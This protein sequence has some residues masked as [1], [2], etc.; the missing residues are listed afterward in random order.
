MVRAQP[1][2]E[3]VSIERLRVETRLVPKERR[4]D[5]E[6][7]VL[8]SGQMCRPRFAPQQRTENGSEISAAAIAHLM[9]GLDQRSGR[10]TLTP[11]RI[12]SRKSGGTSKAR[13]F[14]VMAVSN[15][16]DSLNQ[17]SKPGSR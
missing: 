2:Q 3:F 8:P 1:Y 14:S 10:L 6:R 4:N 15:A 13:N 16:I 9:K 5:I 11:A 17:R 7:L 12:F